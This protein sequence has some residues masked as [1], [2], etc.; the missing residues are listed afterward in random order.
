MT[1]QAHFLHTS[2][3]KTT[4]KMKRI[5]LLVIALALTTPILAQVG[6]YKNIKLFYPGYSFKLDSATGELTA[7]HYD[8][9]TDVLWEE[10]ISPKQSNNHRQTDRYE[11]RRTR[12]IGVYQIFDT[13]TGNYTTVKWK[14][15]DE[16]G[17]EIQADVDT[18]VSNVVNG[19]KK[20][21]KGMEES[22]DTI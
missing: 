4:P 12:K 11:F 5:L 15:K 1:P 21:L 22:L 19:I 3:P 17:K 2:P 20:A 7:V 8:S 18:V 14:P 9:D 16:N 10:V 6:R 13:A